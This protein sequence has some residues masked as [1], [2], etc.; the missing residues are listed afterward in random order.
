MQLHS[1]WH[2]SFT[3]LFTSAAN[4]IFCYW[5]L[6]LAIRIAFWKIF[7]II[8]WINTDNLKQTVENKICWIINLVHYLCEISPEKVLK[9]FACVAPLIMMRLLPT[10]RKGVEITFNATV[11][12]KKFSNSTNSTVLFVAITFEITFVVITCQFYR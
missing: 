6:S 2:K 1:Q 11:I 7:F 4:L 10:V 5:I 8:Y 12:W 3:L 9:A